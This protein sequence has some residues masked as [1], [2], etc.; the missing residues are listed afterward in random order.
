MT[1]VSGRR[2]HVLRF[3]FRRLIFALPPA[4]LL[5]GPVQGEEASTRAAP[6]EN[7]SERR[8]TL[9]E[10]GKGARKS[11]RP[12]LPPK[13][14]R[15][16]SQ[17]VEGRRAEVSDSQTEPSEDGEDQGEVAIIAALCRRFPQATP[18]SFDTLT[19]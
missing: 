11:S 17:Q 6:A 18:A 12:G 14:R 2:S 7:G 13:Q 3:L 5:S 15:E 9:L 4:L 19:W 10:S 1:T 16:E 8:K